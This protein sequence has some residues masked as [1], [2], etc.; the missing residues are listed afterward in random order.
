MSTPQFKHVTPIDLPHYPRDL[1]GYCDNPPKANWKNGAKNCR[2][3]C[4]KP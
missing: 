1:K 2:T 3:V 4:A